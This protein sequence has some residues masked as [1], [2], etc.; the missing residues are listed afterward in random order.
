MFICRFVSY[1]LERLLGGDGWLIVFHRVQYN[2][3]LYTAFGKDELLSKKNPL[4]LSR[5]VGS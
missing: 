5:L 2:E 3:E 1:M 4:I